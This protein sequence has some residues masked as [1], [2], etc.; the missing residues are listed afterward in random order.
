MERTLYPS[1]GSVGHTARPF[2]GHSTASQA[3]G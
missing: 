2:Y 1:T 3:A